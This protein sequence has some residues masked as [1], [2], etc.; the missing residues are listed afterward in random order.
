MVF[1]FHAHARASARGIPD[2]VVH[3]VVSAPE[4]RWPSTSAAGHT[5]TVHQRGAVR[6]VV[7]AD[8]TVVT[9]MWVHAKSGGSDPTPT[10]AARLIEEVMA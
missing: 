5:V 1:A 2:A 8:G 4:L 10:Q 7:G 6:V 3:R 9:V